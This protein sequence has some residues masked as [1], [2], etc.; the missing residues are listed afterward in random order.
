MRHFLFESIYQ[1]TWSFF[2]I[3]CWECIARKVE[4]NENGL[5]VN[6]THYRVTDG[7]M[8]IYRAES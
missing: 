4:E 6:E 1:I 3:F 8:L 2:F 5:K 7:A